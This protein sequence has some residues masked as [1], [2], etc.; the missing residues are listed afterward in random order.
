M[1]S[2]SFN[3]T[4]RTIDHLGKGQIA[5]T[6]T[7]IS[8]LWKN[9]Y[10]A[11][12]RNVAL[13]SFDGDLQCAAV[14]DDGCGMTLEQ[15]VNSWLVVGTNSKTKKQVLPEEDRF[16]LEVRKTQGEKG[17]GRLSAAFLAPIT[18]L[19]S[20]KIDSDYSAL[21]IDWRLFENPYLS[22]SDIKVP[23]KSFKKLEQLE[24]V[25]CEL[26]AELKTNLACD[27]IT[28]SDDDYEVKLRNLK[29]AED[30]VTSTY[31]SILNLKDE[32]QKLHIRR[33]WSLMSNEELEFSPNRVTTEKAITDFCNN[34][35]FDDKI[36]KTWSEYLAN[37]ESL[38][39]KAHGTSLFLLDV[40]RELSLLT[41][42]RGRS[43]DDFELKSIRESITDTLKAFIDPFE[44]E[45]YQFSYEIKTFTN[46]YGS[47]YILNDLDEFNS[48]YFQL[49]EHQIDGEIDDSG[50]FVGKVV[51]FGKDLGVLKYAPNIILK[52][53]K[54][55]VGKFKLKLGAVE[56]KGLS[57]LDDKTNEFITG[58]IEKD[59]GILVFRDGLRVLPYGRTDNDFFDI[60]EERGKHAGRFFWANRRMI[61]Q[62][63]L[64]Q[65]D[66]INLK[67]K[68]GREGFIR[69]QAARELKEL[70]KGHLKNFANKHFGTNADEKRIRL[71][72]FKKEQ[73]EAKSSHKKA[74]RQSQKSFRQSLKSQRPELEKRLEQAKLIAKELESDLVNNIDKLE[75][76]IKVTVDL[77]ELRGELKTPVKPAKMELSLEGTYREY[78][79]LFNEFAELLKVSQDR[80]NQI[81]STLSNKTTFELV[82]RNFDSRQSQLNRQVSKFESLIKSKLDLLKSE[83]QQGMSED[84]RLFH[85]EAIEILDSAKNSTATEEL[86]NSVDGIYYSLADTFTVKYEAILRALETLAAGINLDSAFTIAE[87]ERTY[88]EE[89]ASKLQA[90]AQLGISVEVISHELEQQDQLVSRGLNSLPSEVKEHPGFKTAFN[91][92]KQLTSQIRFLSP[93]KLSG[94]QSREDITGLM[95]EKHIISFFK[96][97]FERQRI[98][99][100][101]SNL[102]RKIVVRDLPSRIYPVFVNLISNA[103]YW[104]VY[105]E[106]R[107]IK[108]DLINNFVVIGNNGPSVDSD[109]VNSLFELFYSRRANGRGVGLYLCKENLAV[110][111]HKIWYAIE[112]DE[113]IFK[114]GANFVIEFN[115][116]SFRNE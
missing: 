23:F 88:F 101:F 55:K 72:I 46:D 95:I 25:V 5:D 59:H 79:D 22:I 8:E 69:N 100:E 110:A 24:Q 19:V 9:S 32:I 65:T 89:K 104:V 87:A 67:D 115:G 37:V 3:T 29:A 17:I 78:R 30:D 112:D 53:N 114:N 116:V 105:A 48:E 28:I 43:S 2:I 58:R 83:W 1:T 80:L 70:I 21:L 27:T 47:D 41:N 107:L 94:Y 76:L 82:K 54:T 90:L 109:D 93:L 60:E 50:W 77:E 73:A 102:F 33:A 26:V 108:I 81:E 20:K 49:M 56:Q 11:Y 14:I 61:G 111:N 44:K 86:L 18:L 84:R 68:A 103:L 35:K 39:G 13:H 15:M 98:T 63:S 6:P 10:D 57:T 106:N 85:S 96:D 7:A 62:I 34:F 66:N 51:A 38:D 64:N 42:N 99:I 71:E 97:S 31:K 4:A 16:G 36:V 52:N 74:R 113:K 12:A 92:H 91:A 45:K 75:E 40:N